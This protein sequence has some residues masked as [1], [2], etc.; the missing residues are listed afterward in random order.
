[1][2]FAKHVPKGWFERPAVG[3]DWRIE[4]TKTKIQIWYFA[5]EDAIGPETFIVCGYGVK[6]KWEERVSCRSQRRFVTALK[7]ARKWIKE[8]AEVENKEG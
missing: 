7:H 4:H 2:P 5:N 3:I 1:M 6:G 8:F